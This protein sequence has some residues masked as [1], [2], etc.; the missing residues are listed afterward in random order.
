[1]SRAGVLEAV[2]TPV[3]LFATSADKLVD[4]GAITRA[5]RRLPRGELVEFG[6]EAAHEVLR[7]SDGVRL[8]V[9]AAIDDFLDRSAPLAA[10]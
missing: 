7:E 5:A 9:W 8:A 6:P 10:G 3:L 4:P 2:Q 1:M